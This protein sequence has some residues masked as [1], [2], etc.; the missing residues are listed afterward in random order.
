MLLQSHVLLEDGTF[1]IKLFPALPGEWKNGKISSITAR[2]NIK[3]SLEWENGQL[4]NCEMLCDENRKCALVGEYEIYED[5]KKIQAEISC[6]N[7]VF[8]LKANT[9]YSVKKY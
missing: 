8:N 1:L 6:G 4:K 9:C 2:G 7:T 5:G 3:V